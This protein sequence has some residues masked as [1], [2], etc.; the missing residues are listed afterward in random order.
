MSV[1]V[2]GSYQELEQYKGLNTSMVHLKKKHRVFFKVICDEHTVEDSVALFNSYRNVLY[3]EYIGL[4]ETL[5]NIDLKGA[6][7]GVVQEFKMDVTVEDVE[8][9]LQGLP[10]GVTLIA[11]LPLECHDMYLVEHL[12]KKYDN[13]RFCG[14]NLFLL[15]GCKIGCCGADTLKSRGLSYTDNVLCKKGC[16]CAFPTYLYSELAVD[17]ITG[18]EYSKHTKTTKAKKQTEVKI[19]I[20]SNKDIL[21]DEPKTKVSKPSTKSGSRFGNLLGAGGIDL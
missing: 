9:V 8:L 15:D 19:P 17:T 14:G 11:K 5:Q 10:K 2:K 3:L 20:K 6:Y 12:S 21:V 13:I 18:V 1:I 16:G 7:I 4:P